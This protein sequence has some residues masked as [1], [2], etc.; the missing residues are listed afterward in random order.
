MGLVPV[1]SRQGLVPSCVPTL[2]ITF[3]WIAYFYWA[4]VR[5]VEPIELAYVA[6]VSFPFPNAR[7]RE[8]NCESAKNKQ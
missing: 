7:E 6:A 8:E 4:I 2:E 3:T 1:T 5:G